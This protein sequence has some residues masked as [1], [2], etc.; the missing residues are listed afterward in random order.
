MKKLLPLRKHGSSVYR[1]AIGLALV[2]TLLLL[3]VNGAVGIIGSE[4]NNVNLLYIVVVGL[5]IVGCF[6]S[7]LQP[8]GMSRT[9]FTAAIAQASVPV[10]AL[11]ILQ[12]V[13]WGGAGVFGVFVLNTCFVALFAGSGWLFR[14]AER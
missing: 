13:S 3:W 14:Q 9:M 5:C 2:P 7:R 1:W 6:F 8:K 11:T 10:I 4:N 12:P